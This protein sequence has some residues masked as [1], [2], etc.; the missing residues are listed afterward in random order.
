MHGA[1]Q[2]HSEFLT[3]FQF[4]KVNKWFRLRVPALPWDILTMSGK[5][6]SAFGGEQG[7]RRAG[8]DEC[9]RSAVFFFGGP[10]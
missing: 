9:F 6:T 4:V 7:A 10:T 3:V 2:R 5:D 1:C 8:R